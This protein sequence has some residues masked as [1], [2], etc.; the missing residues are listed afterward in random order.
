MFQN[1]I[2]SFTLDMCWFSAEKLRDASP[3]VV[4]IGSRMFFKHSF[5]K[6]WD[7]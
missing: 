4:M 3:G 6:N 2:K 1:W 5:N 7:F